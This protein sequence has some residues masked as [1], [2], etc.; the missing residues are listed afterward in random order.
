MKVKKDTV[1]YLSEFGYYNF[2]YPN[3][4]KRISLTENCPIIKKIDWWIHDREYM[5]YL[6]KYKNKLKTVWIE[7]ENIKTC[8]ID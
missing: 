7:K 1:V 6:I 3:K 5:P 8:M 2:I 4:E